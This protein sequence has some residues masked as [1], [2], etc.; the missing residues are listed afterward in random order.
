MKELLKEIIGLL[1]P[2]EYKDDQRKYLY[3]LNEDQKCTRELLDSFG[4]DYKEQKSAMRGVTEFI[5]EVDNDRFTQIQEQIRHDS[6]YSNIVASWDRK[7]ELA[8]LE[9]SGV[10]DT[11]EKFQGTDTRKKIIDIEDLE[12]LAFFEEDSYTV[13]FSLDINGTATIGDYL[14]KVLQ[15]LD[16]TGGVAV[17]GSIKDTTIYKGNMNS[18]ANVHTSA[19][20]NC[21][22]ISLYLDYLTAKIDNVLKGKTATGNFNT[23][24]NETDEDCSTYYTYSPGIGTFLSSYPADTYPTGTKIFAKGGDMGA[25]HGSYLYLEGYTGSAWEIIIDMPDTYTP[26][27]TAT[28]TKEYTQLRWRYHTT[29]GSKPMRV[30]ELAVRK[31]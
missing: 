1:S 31:S 17:N 19:F 4:V 5:V 3:A 15:E 28:T 21:T 2:Q 14:L 29:L 6:N 8:N 22:L 18:R 23:D 25:G 24:G 11:T 7:E 10:I 12:L 26:I 16:I 30:Y 9:L 27:T 13:V 20:N